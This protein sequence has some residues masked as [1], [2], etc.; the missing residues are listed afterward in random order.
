MEPDVLV[1]P[2]DESLA[3]RHTLMSFDRG[4]F[5]RGLVPCRGEVTEGRDH[6]EQEAATVPGAG[7][8]GVRVG[9]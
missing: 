7:R 1:T 3:S 9:H 5:S 4:G 8:T 2:R 6:P